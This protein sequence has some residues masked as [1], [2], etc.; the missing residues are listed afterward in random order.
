MYYF[1]EWSKWKYKTIRILF[2]YISF[3]TVTLWRITR[4]LPSMSTTLVISGLPIV[5]TAAVAGIS[6]L[7]EPS[8]VLLDPLTVHSTREQA[9]TTIFTVT[10]T[11]KVTAITFRKG[12]CKWDSRLE[13]A[14]RDRSLLTPTLV[15]IQWIVSSLKKY[16]K[17]S[18]KLVPY[19]HLDILK[20]ERPVRLVLYFRS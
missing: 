14:S 16:R 8:A 5:T 17:L 7:M 18:S 13:S 19:Y 12:R 1:L 9:E 15:G 20:K 10:A 11:L 2:L 4:T 3:R 6:P